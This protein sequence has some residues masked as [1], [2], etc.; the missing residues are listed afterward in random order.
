MNSARLNRIGAYLFA[1]MDRQKEALAA[2]GVDVIS[3]GIGDPD[4]PTPEHIIEA[5]V[6]AARDPRS[7][8]YPPYGG[9]A[10]FREA[11][12]EWYRRR[13]DVRLDPQTEVLA[14]IGSKEG[15]A[16]LPWALLNPGDATLVPDPGYP[17]YRSA[18]ILAEG[19]PVAFPLDPARGF[20]PE[21][22]AIPPASARR[23]RI[24]FLNYPNNPTA[25]VIERP[26]FEEAV[27]FARAHNLVVAHDNSYSEIAYDG[28]R[29]PSFLQAHGAKEV[30]VEFHSLSKTFCMTGWRIG[31]AVGNAAVIKALGTIKTNVDSGVFGA[32]QEAGIA[33]LLGPREPLQQRVEVYRR[34]RDRATEALTAIGWP[35]P[36]PRATIYLWMAA[37]DGRSG[38]DFAAEVL[39]RTGVLITPGAG[40]GGQGAR[41][42]RISLTT[43]DARLDEALDRLARSFGGETPSSRVGREMPSS[44]VGREAPS[45]RVGGEE[46]SRRSGA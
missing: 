9:S 25:G 3:L 42:V 27:Q 31:F 8:R 40:Y 14:L 37:P 7:H 18:T 35:L 4:L 17:V 19:V 38:A 39:G 36:R 10:D 24:L 44:R 16:H 41:Y 43:P 30:G 46:S 28:F 26:F 23:A 45:S 6:R 15:L 12:A 5:L 20:V 2:Q 32:V 11:V 22:A 33:A 29:P 21:L 13:F 1:D 34:R